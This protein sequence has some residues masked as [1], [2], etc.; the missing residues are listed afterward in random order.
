MKRRLAGPWRDQPLVH[1]PRE[2]SSY[3]LN[4]AAH[5]DNN[6]PMVSSIAK[7]RTHYKKWISTEDLK[8][9]RE[10]V[11]GSGVDVEALEYQFPC[12]VVK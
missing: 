10:S 3:L 4:L 5:P 6:V 11:L 7:F 2:I 8:D 1:L 12:L 9:I